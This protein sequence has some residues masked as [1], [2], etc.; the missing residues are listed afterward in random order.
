MLTSRLSMTCQKREA[1]GIVRHA[2]EHQ[3]GGAV[4]ERAVEDVAVARHPADVGGAPVDVAVVIVEHV[5]VRHRGVDEIAAGGVQ[6][7]LGLAGRAGGVEDEQRVLRAHLHRRAVGV[8]LDQLLVQPD[9]AAGRPW[10]PGA[11][12]AHDQHLLVALALLERLVGVLLERDWPAAAHALVGRD[13][14]LGVGS[15]RCGRRGCR[16][17]SRRTPRSAPRRC[18]RRR[19]WRRPPPGSSAGRR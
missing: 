1:V 11:G 13:D 18:G 5:L 6:H 9:V 17:R 7:A 10:R 16:A 15:R 4:G 12:A 14:E 19:A 3:R 8:D 2:L